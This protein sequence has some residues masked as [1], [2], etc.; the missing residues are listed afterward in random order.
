MQRVNEFELPYRGGDSGVKYLFRGPRVDWGVI[1]LRPG[2][3]LA[4]HYH[5]E[6]EETFFVVRGRGVLRSGGQEHALIPGDA[7]RMEPRD[8][9]EIFNASDDDLK[10]VFIKAP[11]LPEDKVG[12]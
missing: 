10:L 8:D 4:A 7:Y 2:E 1:L 12:L 9:H 11:F 6:V 3:S 5:S